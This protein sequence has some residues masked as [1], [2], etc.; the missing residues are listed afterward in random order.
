ML[1]DLFKPYECLI[2]KT[3][4]IPVASYRLKCGMINLDQAFSW[5]MEDSLE[6][7][8]KN[9]VEKLMS[10]LSNGARL[11]Y[12]AVYDKQK[13]LD[14]IDNNYVTLTPDAK[15][16]SILEFIS[17][18]T[19]YDGQTVPMPTPHPIKVAQM[20]FKNGKEW[21][22]YLL[23]AVEQNLVKRVVVEMEEPGAPVRHNY[24]LTV[25]GLSRLISVTEGRDSR[26]CFIAMAFESDMFEVAELAIK[27]ALSNCGFKH[28]IVSDEHVDSDKTINDAILAGIKRSRFTI[29]DFT[30]HRGGVYFEAGFALGRGQKVIYTCRDDHM[31][32]AHFDIRNYQHIVW[33]DAEDF[34][35]KLINKI[36]AFI[37]E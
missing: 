20:Y 13:L 21:R 22:F 18:Q 33:T 25:T 37:K 28:I 16:N 32:K 35:V 14:F 2:A 11:D 7:T 34:K 23:S 1:S 4:G 30:Y 6:A 12:R 15:L 36:E 26:F 24:A 3:A 9:N 8:L 29:A 17:H 5:Y 10:V 27:P 19:K 31:N